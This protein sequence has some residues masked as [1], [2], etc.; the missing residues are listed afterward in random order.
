MESLKYKVISTKAQ[1]IDYCKKLETLVFAQVKNKNLNDEIAL[2]TL[3]IEKWDSEHTTFNELDPVQLLTSFMNSHNI[4]A[5]DLVTLLGI[6]K[7][8]VSEILN[9]K[10]GF[11]KSI[12]R[13]LSTYFKVSQEAFNRPYALKQHDSVG[14]Q[15]TQIMTTNHKMALN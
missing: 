10:K 15:K 2:L 6:S 14:I 5:K 8:Y 1:Y 9:Y 4:K 11:S 3:L 12:I 13:Q 7:S